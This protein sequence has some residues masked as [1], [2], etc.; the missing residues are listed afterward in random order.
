[1]SEADIRRMFEGIE[2]EDFMRETTA[3]DRYTATTGGAGPFHAFVNEM[4]DMTRISY[5]A[6]SGDMDPIAVLQA[7]DER[8]IFGPDFDETIEQYCNRLQ[9]EARSMNAEWCYIAMRGAVGVY[10]DIANAPMEEISKV[11]LRDPEAIRA[12]EERGLLQEHV[13]WFAE[14][15]E[16]DYEMLRIGVFDELDETGEEPRLTST[17]EGHP[18]GA[19]WLF[20]LVLGT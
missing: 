7:A 5:A 6:H 16:P 8:R 11:N 17:M 4:H 10:R 13:M 20:K 15:R 19:S 9:R 2:P 12:A 18:S 3:T 14:A 1:M